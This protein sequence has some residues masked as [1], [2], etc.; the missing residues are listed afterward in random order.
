MTT[1]VKPIPRFKIVRAY[2]YYSVGQII[3]PTGMLRDG[4]IAG[5]Y[6]EPVRE[7]RETTIA[8]THQTAVA[9][10]PQVKARRGR[11]IGAAS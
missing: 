11:R 1:H 5:G 10:Q 9:P 3:E 4:L 6:I 7:Q 8:P 2:G